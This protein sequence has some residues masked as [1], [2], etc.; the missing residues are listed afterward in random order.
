MRSLIAPIALLCLLPGCE[1]REVATPTAD[2]FDAC[3][4]GFECA[5][6]CEFPMDSLEELGC[7]PGD[8]SSEAPFCDLEDDCAD[9]KRNC[10]AACEADYPPSEGAVPQGQ[11]DCKIECSDNFG[12]DSSCKTD[13]QAWLGEREAVL[14]PYRVCLS[15]CEGRPTRVDCDAGQEDRC[16]PVMYARHLGVEMVEA[17]ILGDDDACAWRCDDPIHGFPTLER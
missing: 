9:A 13:F 11:V 2:R 15:P 12:N 14:N 7:G 10:Y 3:E 4:I 16:D 8:F 5:L 1:V 6:D 17:C